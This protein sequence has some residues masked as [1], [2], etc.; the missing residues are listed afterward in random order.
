M[1]LL[2]EIVLILIVVIGAGVMPAAAW[3]SFSIRQ[4]KEEAQLNNFLSH[5]NLETKEHLQKQSTSRNKYSSNDFFPPVLSSTLICLAGF[6][7]LVYS[8]RMGVFNDDNKNILLIGIYSVAEVKSLFPGYQSVSLEAMLYAF[9]GAYLWSMQV[10]FRRL[11][12]MDLQPATYYRISLRIIFSIFVA[13]VM[14]H[15]IHSTGEFQ[16]TRKVIPYTGFIIGFFP[17]WALIFLKGKVIKLFNFRV[18][19]SDPLPLDMIE[20]ITTFHKF[21]LE[22]AGIENAQNLAK[23]NPVELILRTPYKHQEIMDWIGQA[24][25]YLHFQNNIQRMRALGIRTI[26]DL[27]IIGD[28]KELF[29]QFKE[30]ADLEFSQINLVYHIVK[31]DNETKQL[32]EIAQNIGL[33]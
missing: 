9:L 20:G 12:A 27:M 2:L 32:F 22:E 29:K 19:Q 24:Q 11:I 31:K 14:N 13:L 33:V 6:S 7:L 1:N 10:I 26:Y 28:E 30:Q 16:S 4:Q 18:K 3:S 23:A 21:R 25:L 15:F 8:E 5:L 17:D